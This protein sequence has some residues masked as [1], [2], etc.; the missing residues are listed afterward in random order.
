[1]IKLL[2]YKY[3]NELI[4]KMQEC[5]FGHNE[6]INILS[7]LELLDGKIKTIKIEND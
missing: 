2:T 1:M 5:D 3:E 4:G 7:Y 6:C